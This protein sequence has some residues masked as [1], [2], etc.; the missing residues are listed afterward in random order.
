MSLILANVQVRTSRKNPNFLPKGSYSLGMPPDKFGGRKLPETDLKQ[1]GLKTRIL[2]SGNKVR[3]EHQSYQWDLDKK[4]F[5]IS[6]E[7]STF[8]GTNTF[9]IRDIGYA[10]PE[11]PGTGHVTKAYKQFRNHGLPRYRILFGAFRSATPGMRPWHPHD[12]A[13]TGRRAVI[14]GSECIECWIGKYADGGFNAVW[15]DP[16]KDYLVVRQILNDVV[17]RDRTQ[18]EIT[19][20]AHPELGWVPDKWENTVTGTGGQP[21]ISTH[22]KVED[23]RFNQTVLESEFSLKFPPGMTVLDN[24]DSGG[25]EGRIQPDGRFKPL[26]S[27]TAYELPGNAT[28]STWSRIR[29]AVYAILAL[30]TAIGVAG[31]VRRRTRIAQ[32]SV[33]DSGDL[34]LEKNA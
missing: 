28:P 15:V 12:L 9:D 27:D 1:S 8:D 29:I 30:L 34:N 3:E 13:P 23:F 7:L 22:F 5:W 19:Y 24:L 14:G 25:S 2:V 4:V 11:D 21:G 33:S 32:P 26:D 6:G 18:L 17:G 16:N 20:R 31:L 10:S